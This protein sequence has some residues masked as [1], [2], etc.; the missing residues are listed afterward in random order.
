MSTT[1]DG[2]LSRCIREKVIPP[3][4]LLYVDILRSDVTR[5]QVLEYHLKLPNKIVN[6]YLESTFRDISDRGGVLR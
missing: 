5:L 6:P 3:K 1:P 4:R 2:L